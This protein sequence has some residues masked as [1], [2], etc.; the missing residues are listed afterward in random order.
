[1]GFFKKKKR[2][3]EVPVEG[4]FHGRG[5][6]KKGRRRWWIFRGM[7][8]SFTGALIFSSFYG[9]FRSGAEKYMENPL[10]GS[11]N[12]FWL[13]QNCYLL[14]RDLYNV[15]QGE[16]LGYGDIFLGTDEG[17]RWLL[18]ERKL[19]GYRGLLEL[20]EERGQWETGTEG[21]S[22]SPVGNGVGEEAPESSEES[23]QSDVREESLGQEGSYSRENDS[24]RN[25]LTALGLQEEWLQEGVTAGVLDEDW[26]REY[27]AGGGEDCYDL[28]LGECLKVERGLESLENYFQ[29][30]EDS[31]SHLNSTYDYI[32]KDNA[33]G[34]Y[35]SNMSSEEREREPEAQYFLLSFTFD[36]G[37][38]AA[39]GEDICGTD[40]SRIRRYAGEAL[41]ENV[42]GRIQES[43]WQE[44]GGYLWVK[45][46]VDCTVT[47]AISRENWESMG[48]D[49]QVKTASMDMSYDQG[50]YTVV[51]YRRDGWILHAYLNMG[52]G[53]FLSLA[54]A[55]MAL[56][57]FFL[58]LSGKEKPW[59]EERICSVS[60]ELLCC[61]GAAVCTVM[62]PVVSMVAFV[63][64]GRAGG[65]FTGYL[66]NPEDAWLVAGALN[67]SVLTVF[68]FC[69]WY[70]GICARALREFGM[71]EYIKRR[72]LFYRF[73]PFMKRNLVR[74]YQ[75]M[76]HMDLTRDSHKV[77][78]KLVLVNAVI[79]FFISC[80]WFGGL[81]ITVAY[82]VVLYFILRK[83][84]SGLQDSYRILLKAV[85]E[86]AQG[87]LNVTINEDLGV[88]E[89][90]REQVF[91]IQ[92]GLKKAVDAE[93]KSQRMKAEL[94]TNMSHDL[95]TP[96][97]A[98]ITYAD[99]LKEKDITEAQR[100]EYVATLERK[101]LRLKSL[102]E[103][104]FE[105]SKASSDNVTLNLMDVDIMNLLKQ[106]A[107]EMSDKL[108][109]AQLDVR[110]N[111]TD[112]KIILSLDSQK[113]FRIYENLFGNIAKYALR[114]TR[115]YV[116]GFRID[117]TV[118]ITLK[119]ISAQ[120]ITVAAEELTERF[121]RGD[122][123]RNTEGSGLGLA[124]AKSFTQ[125][126]GGELSLEVDGDLFKVTTLWHLPLGETEG[127]PGPF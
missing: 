18:E 73:F 106:A 36:S 118:V 55:V 7:L 22:T 25:R 27:A 76:A 44:Q 3:G 103:D 75:R 41:R 126:Q 93:V 8:V 83:Y 64:S 45:G 63:A 65:V 104:L 71:K 117:D 116:N 121:V 43:F 98:I 69:C 30:L 119:N 1:M 74:I 33:T 89:P 91:K 12:I 21:D 107:F 78:M 9:V 38:S 28:T 34:Q 101:A 57:G 123:S 88:F 61:V 6:R 100:R 127:L 50:N 46:P 84:I 24:S 86:I 23:G 35:V 31:F 16:Q 97:T 92:E 19:A 94:V 87:R 29:S 52:V 95:K 120:E 53:G 40:Q 109:E 14:Y 5:E 51:I 20:L 122:A 79:L 15:R 39:V 114:G 49:S 80:L 37:G 108:E 124:I 115:V 60:L 72:S 32:I 112:E 105:F 81:G 56:G 96:L 2:R 59:L 99:L 102:I 82:S 17:H 66:T 58:P 4:A 85:D 54:M 113:T 42:L 90:F 111:L 68:F 125:L 70:V 26:L 110:M 11:E 47:F 10:E 77:I 48:G 13:Y 67:L 62:V